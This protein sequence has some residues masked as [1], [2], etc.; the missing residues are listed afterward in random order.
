[1]GVNAK[2]GS[3][4]LCI[5]LAVL[6]AVYVLFVYPV[7]QQARA[8]KIEKAEFLRCWQ[9]SN[10]PDFKG[11]ADYAA[12]KAG[13]SLWTLKTY[14]LRESWFL[15]LVVIAFYGLCRGIVAVGWWIRRGFN[16]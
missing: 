3:N 5:V 7:R 11:C 4:R 6:C 1:M 13:S 16:T 2:R 9:E 14:Y 12:L 8:E 10:P 15:A